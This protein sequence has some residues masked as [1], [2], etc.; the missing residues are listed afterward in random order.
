MELFWLVLPK[1]GMSWL[2]VFAATLLIVAAVEVLER[3]TMGKK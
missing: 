3:L 2:G 1:A